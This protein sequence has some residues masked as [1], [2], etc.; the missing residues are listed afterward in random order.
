MEKVAEH[1]DELIRE[2]PKASAK[3]S[4]AWDAQQSATHRAIDFLS[5]KFRV[6][7][8]GLLPSQYLVATLSVF[9]C[10]RPKQPTPEQLH[11]IRK[12]FW[13]TALGQRYSGRGYRK[14]IVEDAKFFKDLAL[15]T[16]KTF[17]IRELIESD[18][19]LRASYGRRSAIGDAFFCLLISQRPQYLSNGSDMQVSDYASLANRRHKHHI[20]PRQYLQREGVGNRALNSI[21]N[22]CLIPAEEN[23][24]FGARPPRKYLEPFVEQRHFKR[25]ME[26]HLIPCD[27]GSGIWNPE[28]AKGYRIFLQQRTAMVCA[29]FE[30]IAGARL[31]ARERVE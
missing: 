6:L 1:W 24:Q 16:R 14:N 20:F 28:S 31:F 18:E 4:K 21:L 11:A 8:D 13:A 30:R 23:G 25:V 3:F 26:R 12:W 5:A 2:D 22:L 19:L 17:Q 9:F 15:G 7:D 10:H 27:E 29:A